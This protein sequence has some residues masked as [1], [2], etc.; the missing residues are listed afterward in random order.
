MIIIIIMIMI[1]III[2]IKQKE[3]VLGY[4]HTISDI[5]RCLHEELSSGEWTAMIQNWN[6]S[7][8]NVVPERLAERVWWT[9]SQSSL[10][11][12]VFTSVSVGSSPVSY[13]FTFRSLFTLHS[14]VAQ[15]LSHDMGRSTFEIGAA[16]LAPLQKSRRNHCFGMCEEKP[17]PL[18]YMGFVLAEKLFGIQYA[19]LGLAGFTC[20]IIFGKK[21]CLL[22][23]FPSYA[24]FEVFL[25][26]AKAGKSS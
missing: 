3:K 14:R 21:K 2:I 1:M 5:F 16:Q 8:R 23:C 25:M 12:W 17:Y 18:L 11:S 10:A 26:L 13:L 15:S 4:V 22:I 24:R 9:K 7:F 19:V 20:D 6:K